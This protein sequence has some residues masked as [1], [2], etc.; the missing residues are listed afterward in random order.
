MLGSVA[1]RIFRCAACPVLTVGPE[2]HNGLAEG[3]LNVVLHATDFSLAS[4][5]AL[6]YAQ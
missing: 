5:G 3:K 2:V 6:P 4:L 1:E